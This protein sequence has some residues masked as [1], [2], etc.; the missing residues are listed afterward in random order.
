MVNDLLIIAKEESNFKLL[1][2]GWRRVDSASFGWV[3]TGE[4]G[5]EKK[6]F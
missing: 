2:L 4:K 1:E 6:L 5:L 3:R